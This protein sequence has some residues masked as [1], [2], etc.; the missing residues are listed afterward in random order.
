MAGGDAIG[1]RDLRA[2]NFSFGLPVFLTREG[3]GRFG[4]RLAVLSRAL[5][6][7]P[8]LIQADIAGRIFFERQF[9]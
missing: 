1:G 8:D 3:H 7:I 4:R 6:A 2:D 9:K 5:R